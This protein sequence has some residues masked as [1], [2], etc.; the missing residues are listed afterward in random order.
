MRWD[1]IFTNSV[2]VKSNQDDPRK[3]ERYQ[4]ILD[5]L[6]PE[7]DKLKKVMTFKDEQLEWFPAQILALTKQGKVLSESLIWCLVRLLD[8]YAQMDA[9]KNMKA[10]FNNDLSAYKR[11]VPS[12]SES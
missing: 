4:A 8:S 5:M 10:C 11:C 7:I 9:L 1:G 12:R 2:Q 6:E 3:A